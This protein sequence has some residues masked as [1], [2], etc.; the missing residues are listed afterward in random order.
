MI[1]LVSTPYEDDEKIVT[2]SFG[3]ALPAEARVEDF[4]VSA[5][6][7]RQL[8]QRAG[9]YGRYKLPLFRRSLSAGVENKAD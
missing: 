3:D 5:L 8:A 1:L 7:G 9:D 6:R 2:V 4:K